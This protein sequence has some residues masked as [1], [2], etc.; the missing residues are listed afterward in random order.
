MNH[1]DVTIVLCDTTDRDRWDDYV[2]RLSGSTMCHQ[3]GWRQIIERTYG[4]RTYYLAAQRGGRIYGVL[5]LVLVSRPLLGSSLTSMPFLDYGGIG[6]DDPIAGQALLDEARQLMTEHGVS[7][8]ELRQRDQTVQ[9]GVPRLDKVSMVLD[10]SAGSES[11]WRS[12]SPKVRNQVRKAEKSGLSMRIGGAELVEEFYDVFAVNMRD[13]GSPV[14][15]R[16]FFTHMCAVFGPQARLSLVREGNRTV[17]GAVSLFFNDTMYVLWASSLREYFSKCP[18]NL[19]YWD[20]I[21]E[22]CK[23]GCLHFDFGRST[24]GSGTYEFKKQ[25]GAQPVQLHWQLLSSGN[26]AGTTV[27]A[28]DAK[29]RMVADVWRRLPVGVTTLIGPLIRKYLTN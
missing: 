10:L 23:R 14:H 22:A 4:H 24:I 3:F 5:P 28:E 7:M 13:L 21:Q 25:W 17:G 20:A 8:M 6:A 11:L 19:L 2:R 26:T 18:N 15:N 16:A 29:Y 9:V 1:S 12:L 27:S